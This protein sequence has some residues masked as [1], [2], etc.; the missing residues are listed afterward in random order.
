MA[1]VDKIQSLRPESIVKHID[2]YLEIMFLKSKLS[3]A[4]R[5]MMAVVISIVNNCHYCQIHHSEALNHY[6]KDDGNIL[7]LQN[8]YKDARLSEKRIVAMS[9][10]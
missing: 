5:Q 3:R 9:F 7:R 2:L 10:C 4:E 1:E 8:D 6:W